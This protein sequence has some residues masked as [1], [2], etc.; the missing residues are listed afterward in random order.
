[1]LDNFSIEML[2]KAVLLS[3]RAIELEAWGNIDESSLLAVAKTGVDFV[4][5]GALTKHIS[6]I[7]FSLRYDD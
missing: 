5:I 7:D 3:V 2:E 4:S 6:A 1:M